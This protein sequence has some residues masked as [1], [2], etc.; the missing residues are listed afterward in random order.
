MQRRSAAQMK[1]EQADEV[2]A[3]VERGDRTFSLADVRT[4]YY[5]FKMLKTKPSKGDQRGQNLRR[6]SD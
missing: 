6:S 4:L 2:A 3:R 5:G 1:V